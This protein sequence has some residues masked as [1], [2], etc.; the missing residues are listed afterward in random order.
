M[1][2]RFLLTLLALA[3]PT[4]AIAS[5]PVAGRH[6]KDAPVYDV[7]R[8]TSELPS[9]VGKV[10][11][12]RFVARGKNITGIR[13]QWYEG[14][15]WQPNA[16]GK[17]LSFIRVLINQSDLDAFKALTTDPASGQLQ[18]VYGIVAQN[19]EAG[20]LYVRLFRTTGG[21]KKHVPAD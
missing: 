15:V 8:L 12:V 6:W 5:E 17:G 11:G 9:L 21:G 18:V 10:I 13:T 4:L 20:F 1:F 16:T 3:L 14:S 19:P 7:T 2:V